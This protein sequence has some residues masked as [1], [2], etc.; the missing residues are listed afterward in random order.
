MDKAKPNASLERCLAVSSHRFFWDEH[1]VKKL[2]RS[3]DFRS[4]HLANRFNVG[5]TSIETA[6]RKS[7]E[8]AKA[9]FDP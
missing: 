7:T 9:F 3:I 6:F 4:Q 2:D 5:I 8:S 1:I